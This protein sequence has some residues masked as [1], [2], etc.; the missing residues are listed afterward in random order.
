MKVL[1]GLTSLLQLSALL[2]RLCRLSM[3][4]KH[5]QIKLQ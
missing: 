2:A 5:F 3:D 4:P 1:D